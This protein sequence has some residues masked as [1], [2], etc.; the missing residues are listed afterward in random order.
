MSA[1]VFLFYF[2][3]LSVPR[4]YT[5]GALILLAAGLYYCARRLPMGLSRE[6][7]TLAWLLVALFAVSVFSY[8][9]HGNP[10]RSLDLPSR[11]LLA[12]PA[13]MLLVSRPPKPK[14]V[15]SGLIVGCVSAAG[16]T[17]WQV[18][19]LDFERAMGTTGV[20][21][22]GNLGLMMGVFCAAA[23][24]GFFKGDQTWSPCW[25]L[26][27]LVG[28]AAGFYASLASGSRG[29]WIA[30]PAIVIVFIAAYVSRKN[31][32]Y[33]A[34]TVITLLVAAVAAIS[35]VP[36]IEERVDVALSDIQRYQAGDPNT[37][38]GYRFDM[39]RSL[40][41]IIPQKP[42]LGWSYEDY[43]AEQRRLVET[44]QVSDVIIKMAN[45]HN[46]Y[47]E[48]WVFN[49]ALGLAVLLVFLIYAL[50]FF[51]RRLRAPEPQARVAALCGTTLI[52]GYGIFS[53]SQVMLNRNNTL[54]FF[55]VSLAVFWAMAGRSQRRG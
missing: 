8:F 46:T 45:T 24:I 9:Y 2:L 36:A 12:V 18:S 42:W 52:V 6:E 19:V 51:G 53:F 25:R 1:G 15:W 29:G 22:F 40:A 3:M 17:F 13:L 38:L 37:S 47:L 55:L 10:S 39:Y 54:L 14:W 44:G 23:A 41:I 26:A 34:A 30:L 48:F 4:G 16:V 31:V 28:A 32:K 27:L 33:V 21:Q 43:E 11:Y 50:V 35:T 20:I 49:G 5:P 7:K